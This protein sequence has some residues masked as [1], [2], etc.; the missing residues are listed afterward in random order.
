MP[1]LYRLIFL[2]LVAF[3][4]L[5]SNAQ[6]ILISS[7]FS[8]ILTL[9]RET[10][11]IGSFYDLLP[12]D[13]EDMVFF[14]QNKLYLALTGS[15]GKVLKIDFLTKQIERVY[16]IGINNLHG[17]SLSGNILYIA[18]PTTGSILKLDLT[19]EAIA[20]LGGI[21]LSFPYALEASPTGEL[22]ASEI[23]TGEISRINLTS[24]ASTTV[25]TGLDSPTGIAFDSHGSMYIAENGLNRLTRIQPGQ[26]NI[27]GTPDDSRQIISSSIDSILSLESADDGIYIAQGGLRPRISFLDFATDLV[28]Q[29]APLQQI[30]RWI[31]VAPVPEPTSYLL[32]CLGALAFLVMRSR[33]EIPPARGGCSRV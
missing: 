14:G 6:T 26:D 21:G 28:S 25:A 8:N 23:G 27:F 20:H 32:F 1:I 11:Q 9:T 30:P 33:A 17:V 16:S 22:Y 5:A 18:S 3:T 7:Q 10:S 24:G 15:G 13:P 31:A 2:C 29:I 12:G 4:G 19:T